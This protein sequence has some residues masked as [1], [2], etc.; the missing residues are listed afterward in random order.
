MSDD[1]ILLR[2]DMHHIWS[3]GSRGAGRILGNV[4]TMYV[5]DF[6]LECLI[7]RSRYWHMTLFTAVRYG[8]DLFVCITRAN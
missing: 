8:K 6:Q 2:H 4:G 3:R 5:S 1:F 7:P